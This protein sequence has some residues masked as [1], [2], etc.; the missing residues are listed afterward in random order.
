M[1]SGFL[2]HCGWIFAVQVFCPRYA[3]LFVRTCW[4][5]LISV[6]I[7]REAEVK[8]VGFARVVQTKG[9]E[10]ACAG[11]TPNMIKFYPGVQCRMQHFA[12]YRTKLIC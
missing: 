7:G 6:D 3:R 1:F 11:L 10:A 12:A 8:I 2:S 4:S 5:S 9:P